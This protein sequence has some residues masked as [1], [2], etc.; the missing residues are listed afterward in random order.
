M[1]ILRK[2]ETTNEGL[3]IYFDNY[4]IFIPYKTEEPTW[5]K[6][7]EMAALKDH[8]LLTVE[9]GFMVIE[10]TPE[11]N[12]ALREAGK[13]EFN[14]WFWLD[15]EHSKESSRSLCVGMNYGNVC[16]SSKSSNR[17]VRAVSAFKHSL[18]FS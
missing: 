18:K 2:I 10:H 13:S 9:Q 12:R 16:C 15:R 3:N 6:A 5:D 1:D 7:K 14:N 11:I 17:R 8:T 4:G